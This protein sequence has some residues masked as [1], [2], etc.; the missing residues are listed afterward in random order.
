MAEIFDP[1]PAQ[2][3][4]F[5]IEERIMKAA[6]RAEEACEDAFREIDRTARINGEKVLKAFIDNKVSDAC[7][8]GSAG[9]GYGDIG[10]DTL[11]AVFAQALGAEDALVR[12]SIASGTHALTIALFGV[13]RKGDRMVSLTGRPYDLSLIHI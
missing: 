8:K 12:H 5:E 1:K 2:I 7:M 9:Y 3:K 6:Q 4:G 10:R 11:D 13:L